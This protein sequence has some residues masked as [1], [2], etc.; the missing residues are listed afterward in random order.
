MSRRRCALFAVLLSAF[1]GAAP[2]AAQRFG[3]WWWDGEA[4]YADRNQ[5][6]LLDGERISR[7]LERHLRLEL[8]V[9]GYLGHPALGSF[10]LGIEYLGLDLD[11]DTQLRSQQLG[12]SLRLDALPR[13][14]VPFSIAVRRGSYDYSQPNDASAFS[15][16][17]YPDVATTWTGRLRVRKGPLQGLLL[18]ADLSTFEFVDPALDNEIRQVSFADWARD[19]G[20]FRNHFRV[21]RQFNDYSLVDYSTEVW[22]ASFDQFARFSEVWDWQ[23]SLSGIRSDIA[24][25]DDPSSAL[26]DYRL[27]QRLARQVRAGRDLVELRL[28]G[29]LV[30]PELSPEIRGYDSTL[31]YRWRPRPGTEISP[32]LAYADVEGDGNTYRSPRAGL[33]ASQSHTGQRFDSVVAARASYGRVDRGIESARPDEDQAAYS[34]SLTLGHGE[35][36]RLRQELELEAGRNELRLARVEGLPAV[37]PSALFV[38]I[39]D[40]DFG[41]ARLKLERRAATVGIGG[42]VEWSLRQTVLL[43]DEV[44]LDRETLSYNVDL[45]YRRLSLV[46]SAGE[47]RLTS[48]VRPVQRFR[49]VSGTL[50]W[51]LWRAV[52]ARAS[53]RS[54]L[55]DFLS[56]PNL[57]AARAE[58]G[59]VFHYGLLDVRAE[60]FESTEQLALGAERRNRGAYFSITRRFAGWLPFATGAKRRGEIH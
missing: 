42:W 5:E 49:Y 38:G 33:E 47:T 19:L 15:L 46:A 28:Q 44:D 3:Q 23:L 60:L 52:E 8:G 16:L 56:Q 27:L 4:G 50:T 10:R 6:N 30:R 55:R 45:N 48:S 53:Y 40:E 31:F 59:L 35:A 21:E 22:S 34:A 36:S 11:G 51:R 43:P 14:S 9:N 13:G 1:A 2:A 7:Y 32:F 17:S 12:Y 37:E 26:D 57:E 20:P 58:A 54:D 39:G 18:G 25:G 24:F 41:R 29:S